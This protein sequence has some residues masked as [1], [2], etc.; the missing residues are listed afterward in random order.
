MRAKTVLTL[1]GLCQQVCAHCSEV[2]RTQ[3]SLVDSQGRCMDGVKDGPNSSRPPA[4]GLG[5]SNEGPA[6]CWVTP[7][8]WQRSQALGSP[9]SSAQQVPSTSSLPWGVRDP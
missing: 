3:D 4:V 8:E 1:Q 6:K 2:G 5:R 9:P 7:Q